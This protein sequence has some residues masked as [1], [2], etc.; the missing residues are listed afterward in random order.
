MFAI[1]VP[2]VP[3]EMVQAYQSD[4]MISV[5][6]VAAAPGHSFDYIMTSCTDAQHLNVKGNTIRGNFVSPA[7]TLLFGYFKSEKGVDID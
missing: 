3:V 2:S 4:E 6:Q 7:D 1:D 5:H